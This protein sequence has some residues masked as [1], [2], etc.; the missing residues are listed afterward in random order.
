MRLEVRG[1]GTE[2]FNGTYT[3]IKNDDSLKRHVEESALLLKK[4]DALE[5]IS[6][7]AADDDFK[8]ADSWHV[9]QNGTWPAGWY[10]EVWF[11]FECTA[12]YHVPSRQSDAVPLDEWETYA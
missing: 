1:A 5:Y 12:S 11:D 2:R 6:W 3:C 10:M 8:R 9:W 4:D 7:Y